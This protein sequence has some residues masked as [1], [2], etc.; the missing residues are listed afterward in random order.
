MPSQSASIEPRIE[1]FGWVSLREIQTLVWQLH[2]KTA[3]PEATETE[4]HKSNLE[5]EDLRSPETKHISQLT[6]VKHISW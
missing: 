2:Q 1:V 6:S 4:S 5:G 3:E